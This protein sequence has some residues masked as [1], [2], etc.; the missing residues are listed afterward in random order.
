ML[1]HPMTKAALSRALA[2]IH[3]DPEIARE[4]FAMGVYRSGQ[5]GRLHN[6]KVRAYARN[7]GKPCQAPAMETADAS[8]TGACLGRERLR[9]AMCE[10][11]LRWWACGA[12]SIRTDSRLVS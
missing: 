11:L 8:C 12:V 9:K 2:D 3:P 10:R 1:K 6:G 4:F 5:G 7:T